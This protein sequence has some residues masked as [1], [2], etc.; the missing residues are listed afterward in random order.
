MMDVA[1]AAVLIYLEETAVAGF[2]SFFCSPSVADATVQDYSAT[3]DVAATM[4]TDAAT[5][6]GLSFSSSSSMAAAAIIMVA[7][8]S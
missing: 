7:A 4:I 6:S 5:G 1:V 3:T 2:G 8:N